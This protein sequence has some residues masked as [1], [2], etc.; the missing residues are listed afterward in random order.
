MPTSLPEVL[1]APSGSCCDGTGD[2]RGA[3]CA[4]EPF[5]ERGTG[6]SSSRRER[7]LSRRFRRGRKPAGDLTAA[8]TR[9]PLQLL[10]AYF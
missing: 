3:R 6:A 8:F 10:P 9:L 2:S 5:E 1:P 7:G 4:C